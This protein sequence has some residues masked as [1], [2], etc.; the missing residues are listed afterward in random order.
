M[1]EFDI[2]SSLRGNVLVVVF[3]GE[4]TQ[5]NAAAMT[6]RYFDLVLASGRDRILVDL[7]AL[8]GRLSKGAI[9]FLVRDLPVKP[10]PP[11]I[12]TAVLDAAENHEFATFLETTAA[13]AGVNIACFTDAG[14]AHAWIGAAEPA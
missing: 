7:R 14:A 13:N 5:A 2:Q 10:V 1:A 9:Y 8:R 12:R 4:S 3:T 11:S 6:R